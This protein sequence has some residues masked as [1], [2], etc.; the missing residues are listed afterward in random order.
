[1]ANGIA[2]GGQLTTTTHIENFPGHPEA[3]LGVDLMDLCRFVCV[4]VCA[5]A[6]PHT[7]RTVIS[8]SLVC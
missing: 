6:P 7:H 2:A 3:I 5:S 1:M 4:F 8:I